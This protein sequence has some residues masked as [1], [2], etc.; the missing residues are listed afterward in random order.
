MSPSMGRITEVGMSSVRVGSFQVGCEELSYSSE[1]EL[2]RL[3][4]RL[5]WSTSLPMLCGEG[6]K[7]NRLTRNSWRMSRNFRHVGLKARFSY[8]TPE[9]ACDHIWAV[10]C[11]IS[12]CS[13]TNHISVLYSAGSSALQKENAPKGKVGV[14]G[15]GIFLNGFRKRLAPGRQNRTQREAQEDIRH[16]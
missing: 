7:L 11:A 14:P 15:H 2:K 10:L 4:A 8:Q 1:N 9:Q 6:R 12:F 16:G 13:I 5:T 3:V